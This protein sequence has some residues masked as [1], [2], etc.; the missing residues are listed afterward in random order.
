MTENHM[1]TSLH[2][3]IGLFTLFVQH[4]PSLAVSETEKA[5]LPVLVL[6]K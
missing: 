1:S 6:Q 2:F 3:V 4:Q 5:K